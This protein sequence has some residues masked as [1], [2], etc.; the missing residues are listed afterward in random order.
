MRKTLGVSLTALTLLFGGAGVAQAT[1]ACLPKI[2]A[3]VFD[4]V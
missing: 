1:R 4:G 3:W 2:S